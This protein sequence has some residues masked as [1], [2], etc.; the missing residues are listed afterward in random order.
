[1]KILLADDDPI[2]RVRLGGLL[3]RWG[4]DVLVARDG[5]ESWQMLGGENAPAIA[6]LDWRMPGL[7]GPEL[8]R[9][10]RAEMRDRYVYVLL[11]T[12]NQRKEDV[13]AGLEAGADDYLTKPFEPQELSVRLRAG[14]R[15]V[16]LEASLRWQATRDALTRAWN[17]RGIQDLL[18]QELERADREQSSVAVIM[19][20]IDFFKRIN[21]THGHQA[22]DA[23]L[24]ETTSRLR[25]G[26]R[27]YDGVGR[28][29]GEEFLVVA[30]GRRLA[31]SHEIAER[32]RL[33][34]ASEPMAVPG[35]SIPVTASFGFAVGAPG[36]DAA[37][38][39]RAADEALYR[40]KRGGRNRVELAGAEPCALSAHRGEAA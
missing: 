6:I 1:M 27:T 2:T 21:D 30:P 38:L 25:A 7:S 26:L 13:V 19:A 32:M 28:H 24:V 34:I 40:A 37:A 29:G 4:W 12:S 33:R 20:D 36:A 3:E 23:V 14:R 35:A 11:L 9:R 39:I 8:C 16:E 10:I 17:R 18:A 15:I 22:G 31:L 5:V